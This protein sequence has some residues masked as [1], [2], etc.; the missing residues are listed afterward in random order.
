[1]KCFLKPCLLFEIRTLI[2]T[3]HCYGDQI[4]EDEMD[5]II[6][7]HGEMRNEKKKVENPEK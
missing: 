5:G 3:K 2:P 6:K 7:K 1:M 4:K